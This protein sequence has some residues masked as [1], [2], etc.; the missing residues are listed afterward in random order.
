MNKTF[1]KYMYWFCFVA[2]VVLIFV[3]DF[4]WLLLNS[5]R[6]IGNQLH[7]RWMEYMIAFIGVFLTAPYVC[8]PQ[9]KKG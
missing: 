2:S 3:T 4:E 8:N 7:L 6:T 1:E 5:D 9:Q